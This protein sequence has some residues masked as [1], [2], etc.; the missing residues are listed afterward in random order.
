MLGY[1][2]C[3]KPELKV[4][5]FELYNG[6][7]C[8]VCKTIGANYAQIPRMA[9]SY[10]A[11]FLALLLDSI[12]SEYGE[13]TREH[14]PVHWIKK[15]TVV[16]NKSI[17]YASEVMLLLAWYKLIDDANDEG[18]IYA[19]TLMV[20]MKGVYN[21]VSANQPK[22]NEEIKTQLES[23]TKLEDNKC[24]S[25]D[26][27]A[28][29]FA[30][31]MESIFANGLTDTNEMVKLVFQR[32]GFH[33]GKW[34]YLIDA[35]DDIEENIKSG[36]Y[37]PLIYRFEYKNDEG[38]AAFKERIREKV[39]INLITYLSEMAKAFDLLNAK[40]NKDLIENIIYVGLLKKTEEVLGI[41]ED[42]EKIE[43]K[44]EKN[45]S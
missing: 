8:G 30:K 37:N 13:I 24:P 10:D 29:A 5:D 38:A 34:I 36:A 17:D 31:I 43:L 44:E 6:F 40:K 9:L 11:A 19:K 3:Y 39:E 27:A 16:R 7:Y 20:T 18:K 32:L 42:N 4:K 45:K 22:L 2:V 41:N 28:D 26:E 12:E 35:F 14:C 1:V 33:L 15:K 23:L 25:I 21:K